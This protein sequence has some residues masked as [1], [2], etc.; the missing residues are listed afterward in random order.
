[1]RSTVIPSRRRLRPGPCT[2]ACAAT[3]VAVLTIAAPAQA[4]GTTTTLRDADAAAAA[5]VA[6]GEGVTLD[7]ATA[8]VGEDVQIGTYSALDLGAGAESGLALSTGSLIAADPAAEA[9]VDFTTSALVGPNA[10]LTTTGDFGGA[11]YE[12]LA[13]LA[14]TTTYDAAALEL[15]IVPEGAVLELEFRFGSEEYATWA[16]QAY[17]DAVGIWIDGELCSLTPSG[18]AAGIVTINADANADLYTANFDGRTVGTIDTELNGFTA[19]LTCSADVVPGEAVTVALGVADTV[20]GHLDTTLLV[21]AA[22][23]AA[24]ATAS[25]VDPGSSPNPGGGTT[26]SVAGAATSVPSSNKGRGGNLPATGG[27]F[28]PSFALIAGGLLV[29]GAAAYGGSVWYRRRAADAM[30]R[31][32]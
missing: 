17:T 11:G 8:V 4:A 23:I 25:P 27:V 15:T 10:K 28:D 19:P 7:S 3:A 6:I 32:E 13:S 22:S 9:D 18:E 21:S 20:D 24:P 29:A 16:D 2:L 12:P 5:S 30:E 31:S 1:M 14:G 26:G